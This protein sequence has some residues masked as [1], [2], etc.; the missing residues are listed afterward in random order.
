M[1]DL[2]LSFFTNAPES[3]FNTSGEVANIS[4]GVGAK[5]MKLPR[6]FQSAQNNLKTSD[7]LLLQLS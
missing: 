3:I 7:L 6:F 5:L 1:E 4:G 2:F